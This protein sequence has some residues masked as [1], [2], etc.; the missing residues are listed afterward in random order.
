LRD[1][2]RPG[3]VRSRICAIHAALRLKSLAVEGTA[4]LSSGAREE[5]AGDAHDLV[6]RAA[7]FRIEADL[8]RARAYATSEP[9]I[10]E[11]Y[12]ALANR[13]SNFAAG[14]EAHLF[15]RLG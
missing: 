10:R 8:L 11:E 1:T 2:L 12:L 6:R 5:G 9:V 4:F 7:I 15:L 13:W 3:F 14:L